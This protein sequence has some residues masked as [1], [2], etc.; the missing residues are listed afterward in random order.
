MTNCCSEVGHAHE[1]ALDLSVNFR[2]GAESPG[3][4]GSPA[5]A[6]G[7]AMT[8]ICSA[9]EEMFGQ[10]E[11]FGPGEI[12]ALDQS[13][14]FRPGNCTAAMSCPAVTYICPEG[15]CVVSTNQD[16]GQATAAAGR[17]ASELVSVVVRQPSC[18]VS[19]V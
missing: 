10:S 12:D 5:V 6:S 4:A 19:E 13:E 2:P 17:D 9:A 7:P 14:N 18:A 15:S 3:S 8:N 11:N 1:K 16:E